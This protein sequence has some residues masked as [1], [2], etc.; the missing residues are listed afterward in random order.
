MSKVK[1]EN[2]ASMSETEMR[3]AGLIIIVGGIVSGAVALA[4]VPG[5]LPVTMFFSFL[6]GLHTAE[7]VSY[8][9]QSD[10][11]KKTVDSMRKQ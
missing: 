6:G 2:E 10:E 1:V 3:I 11:E 4:A 7:V 5:G 8:F 9:R